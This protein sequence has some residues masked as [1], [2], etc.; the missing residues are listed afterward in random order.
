M[1]TLS[2][3]PDQTKLHFVSVDLDAGMLIHVYDLT[4]GTYDPLHALTRDYGSEN[5][6]QVYPN[7]DRYVIFKAEPRPG[8]RD[9]CY[10]DLS[11]E[12]LRSFE[13]ISEDGDIATPCWSAD[14]RFIYYRF[15][16]NDNDAPW[17]FLRIEIDRTDILQQAGPPDTLY[18]GYDMY[19]PLPGPEDEYM[20][21]QRGTREEAILWILNLQTGETRELAKGSFPALS[22]SRNDVYFKSGHGIHRIGRWWEGFQRV[23]ESEFIV[24]FP[25][26]VQGMDIGPCLAVSDEALFAVLTHEAPGH[27]KVFRMP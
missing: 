13:G 19:N 10:W 15:I 8:F 4:A 7:D 14:G 27:I 9:L 3:S 2:V 5:Y 24:G 1:L 12:R 18:S 22:P 21:Y 17:Y 20:V 16:P 11:Q 23:L 26:G 25:A 6:P